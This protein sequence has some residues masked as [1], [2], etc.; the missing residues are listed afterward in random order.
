MPVLDK[1]IP[2]ILGSRLGQERQKDLQI[3]HDALVQEH[4]VDISYYLESD[5]A[6][7]SSYSS[8]ED[9]IPKSKCRKLTILKGTTRLG[10]L[11][12]IARHLK[13]SPF[14]LRLFSVELREQGR[15]ASGFR[16]SV[17]AAGWLCNWKE[18]GHKCTTS[19]I[20]VHIVKDEV[21]SPH[22]IQAYS[23][24]FDALE[25]EDGK[26]QHSFAHFLSTEGR[27]GLINDAIL[28][29][30]R[31][32]SQDCGAGM[33]NTP[34]E[35]IRDKNTR[36]DFKKK[37][38]KMNVE[39]ATVCNSFAC[40]FLEGYEQ[41]RLCFFKAYDPTGTIPLW[42]DAHNI[43][44]EDV[45]DAPTANVDNIDTDE[46]VVDDRVALYNARRKDLLQCPVRYLGC[47]YIDASE[48]PVFVLADT[49]YQLILR[50]KA[51]LAA[52][53]LPSNDGDTWWNNIHNILMWNFV[54]VT[55]TKQLIRPDSKNVVSGVSLEKFLAAEQQS[56]RNGDM[57]CCEE[58]K[59][60]INHI[61][62]NIISMDSVDLTNISVG[63]WVSFYSQLKGLS[64]VPYS[65]EDM[66][67]V[68]GLL[69]VENGA[70][71]TTEDLDDK[72][73]LA[74]V[75]AE[76]VTIDTVADLITAEVDS[77]DLDAEQKPSKSIQLD[78]PMYLHMDTVCSL[79]ADSLAKGIS[80]KRLLLYPYQSG[81]TII[82]V[83]VS[84]AVRSVYAQEKLVQQPM[85][86][87]TSSTLLHELLSIRKARMKTV[88]FK[89]RITPFPTVVVEHSNVLHPQG[90]GLKSE[91]TEKLCYDAGFRQFELTINDERL[92]ALRRFYLAV[93]YPEETKHFTLAQ[94]DAL[95]AVDVLTHA[96]DV[97]DY[98]A[99]MV[100]NE[101]LVGMAPSLTLSDAC[102]PEGN[103]NYLSDHFGYSWPI[104][105]MQEDVVT[106]AFLSDKVFYI[107]GMKEA[108][109]STRDLMTLARPFVGLPKC[110]SV[111]PAQHSIVDLC[112]WLTHDFITSKFTL[113]IY[114]YNARAD[115]CQAF[116]KDYP[117]SNFPLT[118]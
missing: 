9:F 33:G 85:A 71:A 106:P 111:A 43:T 114:K 50:A 82:P 99:A 41:K 78:I 112:P 74:K 23:A 90:G 58:N 94:S 98:K 69:E 104:P 56:L 81:G 11:L 31:N 37:Y 68:N 118:W 20:Y 35:W 29:G 75:V 103:F 19:H 21:I 3:R 57:F 105:A 108:L 38:I 49:C 88:G 8:T 115:I 15:Q 109:V 40:E 51:S 59:H 102:V 77:I 1:D 6:M 113:I 53:G 100:K 72:A 13:T 10:V 65:I 84:A 89:Y 16:L 22:S 52:Q 110:L 45:F 63:Q 97:D 96:G 44:A 116:Y 66:N 86:S 14:L 64:V 79:V 34:L 117:V 25:E 4:F 7:F 107:R 93:L 91:E 24:K 28:A 48:E 55:V 36:D 17:D 5:V 80:P 95:R 70:I 32:W 60:D 18:L 42:V 46:E 62:N 26:W 12:R 83:T 73:A 67:I 101:H 87:S 30:G 27:T 92:R 47:R 61:E 54:S 2:S 39:Y 76:K